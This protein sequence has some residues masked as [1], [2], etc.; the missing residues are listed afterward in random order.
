MIKRRESLG[1]EIVHLPRSTAD[2]NRDELALLLQE[3]WGAH[4]SAKKHGEQLINL[5]WE[6]VEELRRLGIAG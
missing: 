5:T 6:S 2:L 1:K 3:I 4:P